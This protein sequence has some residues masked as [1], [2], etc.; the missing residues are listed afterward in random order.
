MKIKLLTLFSI[1]ALGIAARAEATLKLTGVHN[2]CKKCTTGITD[3]ITKAGATV[4]I[5]KGDVTISA[6]DEAGAKKAASALVAA[7]YFGNGSEAPT[8]LSDAKAKSVTVEG[9]H[10]C[11]GKCVDAFN[12]AAMSAPGVTKTNAAKGATS[13]TV[14]GDVSPKDLIAALNK[15]GFNGRVK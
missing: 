10:L 7:G 13:V 14:E 15:G 5:D 9:A 8:G 11:C 1:L 12:K 3:A 6:K 2:C 4:T